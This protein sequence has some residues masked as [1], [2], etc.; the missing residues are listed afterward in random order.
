MAV[1]D[2]NYN[3]ICVDIGAYGKNSDG[4]IFSNSRIGKSLAEN[5]LN[6]PEDRNIPNTQI[7]LPHVFVGD[8]AFPLKSYLMRPYPQPQTNDPLKRNFN[9][10]LSRGRKVV[11]NAFGQLAQKFRIYN[12][13]IQLKPENADKVILTTCI[14]H[15][16]IKHNHIHATESRNVLD[17]RCLP[18]Q[19]G[20][21][22]SS[23]FSVRDTLASFFGSPEGAM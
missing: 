7:S 12:R 8:E 22:Q 4:G 16:F 11:E 3:F 6:V 10:R 15:N 17:L 23:A 19:G 2:A 21:S 20:R 13:R 5:T 9:D 18:R 14:L 1:V